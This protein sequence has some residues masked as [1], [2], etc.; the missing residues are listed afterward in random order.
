MNAGDVDERQNHLIGILTAYAMVVIELV[1]LESRLGF[2][3]GVGHEAEVVVDGAI[4]PF[5][6]QFLRKGQC[7]AGIPVH[8]VIVYVIVLQPNVV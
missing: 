4:T 7:F 8:G 2:A 1:I 3:T 5:P 6:F